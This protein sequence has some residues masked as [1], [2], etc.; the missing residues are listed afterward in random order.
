MIQCLLAKSYSKSKHPSMTNWKVEGGEVKE[1][2]KL[3]ESFLYFFY[4]VFFHFFHSLF[5]ATFFS[6]LF[7]AEKDHRKFQNKWKQDMDYRRK[8]ARTST[9]NR[10]V[11]K[12]RWPKSRSSGP[13][14]AKI[15]SLNPLSREN[16]MRNFLQISR[17]YLFALFRV[18]SEK[19]RPF[20]WGYLKLG[21]QQ[22]QKR[23]TW[24]GWW[25]T[26]GWW[27]KQG[28]YDDEQTLT[29]N[30]LNHRGWKLS[31]ATENEYCGTMVMGQRKLFFWLFVD[32]RYEKQI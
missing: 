13:I 28:H 7:T 9:S 29:S 25:K 17:M 30:K 1:E 21:F 4:T 22:R 3:A 5:F 14:F 15:R 16:Q 12:L 11:P 8:T 6:L 20:Y 2:T 23:R 24:C 26:D 10:S 27:W 32:S 18:P 31:K 19:L